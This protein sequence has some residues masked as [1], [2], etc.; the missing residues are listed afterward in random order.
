MRNSRHLFCLPIEGRID[1][2]DYYIKL[3]EENKEAKDAEL[4]V[5]KQNFFVIFWYKK[6]SLKKKNKT[7]NLSNH[8]NFT[9]TINIYFY[10][11]FQNAENTLEAAGKELLCPFKIA[12]Q[13]DRDVA[14]FKDPDSNADDEALGEINMFQVCGHNIIA[15]GWATHAT[16][17]ESRVN[18]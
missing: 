2:K 8:T 16:P 14:H 13:A 10:I 11:L 5:R 17:I 6:I 9:R 1:R 15:D 4:S 18:N 12:E 3:R 7:D